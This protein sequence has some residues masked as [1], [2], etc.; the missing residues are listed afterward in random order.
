MKSGRPLQFDPD[1]AVAKATELFWKQGYEA[2]S[3]ADLMAAMRLSKSSLYQTFSSKQ[4]LFNLCIKHYGD[5]SDQR[6]KAALK[7]APSAKQFLVSMFERFNQPCT[8]D[9]KGW[10]G[11]A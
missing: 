11:L 1:E 9:K 5:E 2:T 3:T 4:D 10:I 8:D 6:F 7:E